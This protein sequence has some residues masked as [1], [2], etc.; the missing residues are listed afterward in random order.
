[1]SRRRVA[2]AAV[3]VG[4]TVAGGLSLPGSSA[5]LQGQSR[6]PGSVFGMGRP[7]QEESLAETA[8]RA[9]C[10]AA[11]AEPCPA[12]QDFVPP[13]LRE[14][15]AAGADES[16]EPPPVAVTAAPRAPATASPSP[17]PS[18]EPEEGCREPRCVDEAVLVV[19]EFADEL[20]DLEQEEPGRVPERAVRTIGEFADGLRELP[21]P[22]DDDL[23][24]PED[25]REALGELV[26]A[27]V[28][29]PFP[30]QCVTNVGELAEL[31]ASRDGAADGEPSPSPEACATPSPSPSPSRRPEPTPNPSARPS[32]SPSP[33]PTEYPYDGP[34]HRVRQAG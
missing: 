31:V 28:L 24:L 18:P 3:V 20:R 19:G 4:L 16:V 23:P 30:P 13:W 11:A 22:P 5:Y 12:P 6:T 33:T 8:R 10:E 2:V 34:G 27:G 1:M 26:E 15:G 9:L 17:S 29:E 25:T 7:P 32:P 14:P 21:E